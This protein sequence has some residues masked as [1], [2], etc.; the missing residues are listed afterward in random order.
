MRTKVDNNMA[1]LL[2][3][4]NI[5]LT[6]NS[7]QEKQ[8]S[9]LENNK[10][11]VDLK[12]SHLE[13][14]DLFL[15]EANRMLVEKVSQIEVFKEYP[16]EKYNQLRENIGRYVSE[17]SDLKLYIEKYNYKLTTNFSE[18]LK[19]LESLIKLIQNRIENIERRQSKEVE[20]LSLRK[21]S[22]SEQ[23]AVTPATNYMEDQ[24]VEVE[25][26]KDLKEAESWPGLA[27]ENLWRLIL[28]IYAAFR[29]ITV[30]VKSSGPV[31]T[32]Y[33]DIL[34]VYRMV[35]SYNDRPVYK[36][37]GGENYIYYSPTPTSWLLGTV[38]GHHYGWLRNNSNMASSTNWLPEL[39]TGW[40]YRG[41]G[42]QECWVSDD[43]TL[44]IEAIRD[45]DKISSL[46]EELRSQ[47]EKK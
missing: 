42:D 19:E 15:Q 41:V 26:A 20:Q 11:D 5:L 44:R 13:S 37:E 22:T 21:V 47:Y 46:V 1:N 32:Y 30:L 27:T 6:K 25:E 10:N 2:E 23:Q 12:L 29:Y 34:G 18:H 16:E 31:Y 7:N 4:T 40:Q 28:E 33:S 8:L 39:T 24:E 9:E 17:L 35:D 3:Q 45:V 14:A 43:T 38:I 36:Q